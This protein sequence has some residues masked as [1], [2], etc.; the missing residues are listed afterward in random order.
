M[1]GATE[2]L[3]CFCSFG[4]HRRQSIALQDRLYASKSNTIWQQ[5][6]NSTGWVTSPAPDQHTWESTHK[7][8]W[9]S[10]SNSTEGQSEVSL[11]ETLVTSSV[12]SVLAVHTTERILYLRP[13]YMQIF[14]LT[15]AAACTVLQ[16]RPASDITCRSAGTPRIAAA[17]LLSRWGNFM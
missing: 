5:L 8:V 17:L 16:L 7:P 2:L 1:A 12:I 3:R 6:R 9:L 13:A 14:H 11:F 15:A 10:A 4:L